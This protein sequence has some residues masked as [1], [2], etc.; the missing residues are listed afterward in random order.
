MIILKNKYLA[1]LKIYYWL[2]GYSPWTQAKRLL[3]F[4]KY[5][6][7]PM[8][9]DRV[10]VMDT[11]FA[12][13]EYFAREGVEC[14]FFLRRISKREKLNILIRLF[15]YIDQLKPALKK[16]SKYFATN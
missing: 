2:K 4:Y 12:I 7:T 8:F 3:A 15:F 6:E 11:K 13:E 14:K 10:K 9:K 16:Y 5:T 1:I